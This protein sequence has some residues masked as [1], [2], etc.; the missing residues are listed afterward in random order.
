MKKFIY[1]YVAIGFFTLSS[2][3]TKDNTLLE[4]TCRYRLYNTSGQ[5]IG[6]VQ[7]DAPDNVD[8][9]SSKAK[10]LARAIFDVYGSNW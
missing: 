9:S 2:F 8:C 5:V 10:A 1:G 3:T 6:T 7:F 4:H